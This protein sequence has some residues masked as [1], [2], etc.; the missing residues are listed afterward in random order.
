MWNW[1]A[2][3]GQHRLLSKYFSANGSLG[4]WHQYSLLWLWVVSTND[5]GYFCLH[6]S[7]DPCLPS[8]GGALSV[9]VMYLPALSLSSGVFLYPELWIDIYAEEA[10]SFYNNQWSSPLIIWLFSWKK[11][12]S[13]QGIKSSRAC[14]KRP[15]MLMLY[16]I[17][18]YGAHQL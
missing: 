4:N 1:T 5:R 18:A 6:I 9:E 12:S 16:N 3:H 2:R 14:C 13:Q 7:C 17:N 11:R 8:P 15:T 10:Y